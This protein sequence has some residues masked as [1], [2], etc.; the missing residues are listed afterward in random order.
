MKNFI[1]FGR[2]GVGKS[3]LI[4]SVFG[5][6]IAATSAYEACTKIVTHYAY[7]SAWGD[8]K[9]IDTPGLCES[10]DDA[11]DKYYMQMVWES[12]SLDNIYS[13]VYVSKLD[14]TRFRSDEKRVLKNLYTYSKYSFWKTRPIL[15]FT[16]AANVTS[17][18]EAIYKRTTQIGDYLF[19]LTNAFKG[20]HDIWC[21]DNVNH[22]WCKNGLPADSFLNI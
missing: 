3:S 2:T 10:Y 6:S 1:F 19:E 16:F 12:I 4:N 22:A 15:I 11:R 7:N 9:L 8:V 20:F 18:D 17:V 5:K 14:D 21:I 13:I